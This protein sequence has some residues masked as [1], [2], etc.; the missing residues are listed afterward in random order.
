MAKAIRN[1]GASVRA[2]LLALAKQRN[3]QFQLL[4]T[5]FVLERF[6]YRL[7]LTA[8]RNRFVLKGAML[9]TAW[10]DNPHRSTRDIDLLGFGDTDQNAI[11][12]VFSEISGIKLDDG[13]EFD[14]AALRIDRIREAM[15]YGGLRVRTIA[16]VGEA[17]VNVVIDIGFGDATEPGIEEVEISALLDFPAPQLRAYARETVIAEKFQA[18][19]HLGRANSRMKDYYDIWLLSRSHEFT[20]D[21]IARAIAATFARR[22]TTI[23]AEPPDGLKRAF[24]GDPIKLQQW[25]SFMSDIAAQASPFPEVVEDLAAFLMPHAVAALRLASAMAKNPSKPGAA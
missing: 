13:V 24:A 22:R 11:L 14:A 7:G 16:A 4:L 17:R 15:E 1:I 6:L 23:P 21:R 3:L 19:V 8:Y 5:R 18:M 25:A 9:V 12:N 2:R 20:G 10:F